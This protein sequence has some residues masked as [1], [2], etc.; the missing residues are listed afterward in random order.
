M[1]RIQLKD[2]E[3]I[4][5]VFEVQTR[6]QYRFQKLRLLPNGGGQ[7]Q[8]NSE[9]DISKLIQ[10]GE[11]EKLFGRKDWQLLFKNAKKIDAELGIMTASLENLEDIWA[12]TQVAHYNKIT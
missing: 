8:C 7:I 10:N 2:P 3:I 12:K 11:I 5:A 6:T 9:S 4:R 1:Q